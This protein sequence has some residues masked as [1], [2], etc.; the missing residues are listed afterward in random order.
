M[1]KLVWTTI[2]KILRE[3]NDLVRTKKHHILRNVKEKLIEDNKKG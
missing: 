3:A 2:D 1:E